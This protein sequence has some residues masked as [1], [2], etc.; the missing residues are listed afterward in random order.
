[1]FL[2]HIATIIDFDNYKGRYNL[3]MRFVDGISL[4][5]RIK[6]QGNLPWSECIH[7]L[8]DVTSG[9]EYAHRHGLVHRDNKPANILLSREEGA[10]LT[11]FWLVKAAQVNDLSSTS[12]MLSPPNYIASG[13]MRTPTLS[14]GISSFKMAKC[15]E[16]M[17]IH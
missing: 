14:I 10:V 7:I 13:M 16:L 4:D 2:E 12:A 6:E 9:F 17:E 11:D 8:E 1:L 15:L 3:V 5:K